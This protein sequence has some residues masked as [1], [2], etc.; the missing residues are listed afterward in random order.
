MVKKYTPMIDEQWYQYEPE[1]TRTAEMEEN[2]HGEWVKLSTYL[3][4]TARLKAQIE[5]L[6]QQ[7]KSLQKGVNHG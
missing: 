2:Q 5:R 7:V 1:P 3:N 6:K 4:E